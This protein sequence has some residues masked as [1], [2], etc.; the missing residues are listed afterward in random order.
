MIFATPRVKYCADRFRFYTAAVRLN[1]ILLGTALVLLAAFGNGCSGIN[2][3][4]SV[5]PLTFFLPGFVKNDSKQ[6]TPPVAAVEHG[7]GEDSVY[8]N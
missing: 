3:S 8:P 5:S 4:G 6:T 1:R 2:A 7:N